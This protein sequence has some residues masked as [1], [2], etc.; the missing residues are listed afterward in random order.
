MKAK[1]EKS[2]PTIASRK[3][4]GRLDEETKAKIV[5][6]VNNGLLSERAAGR[7]Y[8]LPKSTIGMWRDSII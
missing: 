6:E 2:K 1:T 3:P 8:G 5:S 4:W 7:K